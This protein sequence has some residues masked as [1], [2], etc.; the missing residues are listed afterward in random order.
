MKQR[1]E[2]QAQLEQD[3]AIAHT[4]LVQLRKEIEEK[5]THNEDLKK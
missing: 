3:I 4:E 2:R 1:R 5:N